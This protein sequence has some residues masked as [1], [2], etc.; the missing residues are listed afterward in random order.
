MNN[1]K[2]SLLSLPPTEA[3]KYLLEGE[4]YCTFDL[5]K[6]FTFN[7]LLQKVDTFVKDK[8]L[9]TFSAKN[10]DGKAIRACD[11]DDINYK[12]ISNK[13]GHYAWRPLQLIHPALYVSLIQ[14]ITEKNNWQAIKKRFIKFQKNKKIECVSI[15][16]ISI[17]KKRTQ[18]SAQIL[19]WWEEVEQKSLSKAL[20]FSYLYT[21]DIT[22][23]YGAIYTHSIA[24]ALHDKAFIKNPINRNNNKLIGNKIDSL[25]REMS[26]GQTNGIPQGS[27]SMD[28]IEEILIGYADI[29]LT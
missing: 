17:N 9:S 25:L 21:T 19:T 1:S 11:F 3:K 16:V 14:T 22:D 12:I 15:P 23:C 7:E 6:Y 20:D 26:N 28:F 2:K 18:A 4:Q 8:P 10:S 29:E 13:D 24:W 27:V 5:P